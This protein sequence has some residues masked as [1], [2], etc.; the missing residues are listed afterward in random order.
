M[1]N[2]RNQGL[3]MGAVHLQ[4]GSR[5]AVSTARSMDPFSIVYIIA[6]VIFETSPDNAWGKKNSYKVVMV[7]FKS[8]SISGAQGGEASHLILT[9]FDPHTKTASTK[10]VNHPSSSNPQL[11]PI[12]QHFPSNQVQIHP[13]GRA[14]RRDQSRKYIVGLHCHFP[15]L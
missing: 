2:L 7:E 11:Q 12:S 10:T 13:V 3:R 4:T 14:T 9:E 6:I 15:P 8:I 5:R 1:W